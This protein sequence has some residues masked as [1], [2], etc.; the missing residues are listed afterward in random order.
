MIGSKPPLTRIRESLIS[1]RCTNLSDG[2]SFPLVIC[3]ISLGTRHIVYKIYIC[4]STKE[5]E[6]RTCGG[7]VELSLR[8][9]EEV[10]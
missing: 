8:C 1:V 5:G 7:G 2:V 4:T 3:F 6:R 10:K 9:M